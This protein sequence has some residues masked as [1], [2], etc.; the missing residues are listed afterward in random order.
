MF[1]AATTPLPYKV[2]LYFAAPM[3]C[4]L[5][6]RAALLGQGISTLLDQKENNYSLVSSLSS[7]SNTIYTE[8]I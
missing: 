3:M 7:L 5:N 1:F 4:R 6:G 8:L 2:R